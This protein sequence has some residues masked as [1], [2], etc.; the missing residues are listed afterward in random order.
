MTF[1][2]CAPRNEQLSSLEFRRYVELNYAGHYRLL[3]L[4]ILC[5]L[6]SQSHIGLER[7]SQPPPSARHRARPAFALWRPIPCAGERFSRGTLK[8]LN[9]LRLSSAS[10][11]LLL[12]DQRTPRMDGVQF[13]QKAREIFPEAKRALLTAYADTNAAISAIKTAERNPE[14]LGSLVKFIGFV[15]IS[16]TT[17]TL[18]GISHSELNLPHLQAQFARVQESLLELVWRWAL[19]LSRYQIPSLRRLTRSRGP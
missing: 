13:L 8:L 12:A 15:E 1:P 5:L 3:L 2:F 9:Q 10:V 16:C 14:Q 19:K 18:H 6:A 7:R 17:D 4:E 11:A